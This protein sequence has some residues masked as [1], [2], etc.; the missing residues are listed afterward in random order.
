MVLN[1]LASGSGLFESEVLDHV[2]QSDTQRRSNLQKAV[3]CYR[4][5]RSF[6]LT[7]VNR[8]QV[9]FFRQHVLA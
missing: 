7:D 9:S 2:T 3:D 6:D 1:R 4:A 5:V 8:V